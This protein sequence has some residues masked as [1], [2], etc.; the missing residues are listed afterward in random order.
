MSRLLFSLLLFCPAAYALVS[1]ADVAKQVQE[2][3]LDPGE[4]YRVIEQSYAKEDVRIFFTSGYM[5]FARPVNGVRAAVVFT[6]DVES[7]DGEVLVLP[8]VRSERLSL[9]NFT[10]SPNLDEHFRSALILATD[11]TAEDLLGILRASGAKKAPEMGALLSERW[12]PVA[13]NLNVSLQVRQVND[14]LSGRPK[15]G[16]F[17]MTVSGVKLGNFDVVCDPRGEDNILVGQVG[18]RNGRMY[19]NVWTSFASRSRRQAGPGARPSDL[20]VDHYRIEATVGQDLVLKAVTRFTGTPRQQSRAFGFTISQK[21]R[22]LE[23]RI[24][25]QPA[26]VF[27]RESLRSNLIHANDDQDFLVI[28]P[29]ELDPAKPHEFE[30]RHEGAVIS[31]AGERVY[32]VGARSTWY[33]RQGTE[34]ARYDL[35]FRYPK[36]LGFVATGE[37]VEDKVEGDWRITRR[38]TD[39]PIRFAGFNLG[40]YKSMI[41]SHDQYRVEVYANRRL[42]AALKPRV[43]PSLDPEIAKWSQR[44]PTEVIDSTGGP[45][46][47][48]NPPTRLETL[49]RDIAGAF[50]YYVSQFGP[51]PLKTLTVSPI[52]GGFG[53]GFPGLLY[54]STLAYLDPGERPSNAQDRFVKAFFTDLLDAHEVAHQWWGNLVIGDGYQDAWLTEALANYSALLYLEK[55]KGPHYVDTILD[56]YRTHL[57]ELGPNARTLESAGPISW[58]YRLESSQ[59]PDAWHHIIYEKGTWV[60]HMMR[61]RMGDEGFLAMLRALSQ[62]YRY[63]AINTEQFR[64]LA[65]EFMPPH[66][67]DA[68]LTAFFDTWVYGTGIP[69]LKMTSS[70]SGLKITGTVSQ[71]GVPNDF[72]TSIPIEVQSG[73]QRTLHW[74]VT[75]DEPVP[76]SIP[77][78][79]PNGKAALS[80]KDALFTLQK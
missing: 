30:I 58:G 28:A 19:F 50:D 52:P 40:D 54:L 1:A 5:I 45:P 65:A 7:G 23:A 71:S 11:N 69:A 77:V 72:S 18:E 62:R 13:G 21:M 42:E 51:P 70:A 80:T 79:G 39:V 14:I 56:D 44:H 73:R 9:V 2:A 34:F 10:D 33:P 24:D 12:G 60:M 17:Y 37:V 16:L 43:A 36:D 32:Y 3:G 61:R 59:S 15:S 20:A 76:F 64:Q 46:N 49:A 67:S 78:K 8:P 41:V 35:T 63:K 55:K 68:S 66:T 75:S 22:V 31:T 53:Q 27:E 47:L 25:G 26:E 57:L 29:S 38:T 4:C 74:V 6:T 48:P